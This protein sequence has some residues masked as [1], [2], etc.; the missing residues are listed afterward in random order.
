MSSELFANS[1]L[2]LAQY[3]SNQG[4]ILQGKTDV[5]QT[6]SNP[7]NT[8]SYSNS[9]PMVFKINKNGDTWLEDARIVVLVSAATG[10]GGTYIRFVNAAGIFIFERFQLFQKGVEVDNSTADQVFTNLLF[11]KSQEELL[12]I[13]PRIAYD[14]TVNSVTN[15]NTLA[16]SQQ[17]FVLDVRRMFGFFNKPLDISLIDGDLEVRAWF[18]NNLTY[19]LQTDKT[20]PT[21]SILDCY[22]DI[23]YVVPSQKIVEATRNQY[24]K[25]G[26]I[27][28]PKYDYEL[29]VNDSNILLAGS[30]ATSL[31]LPEL[32]NKLVV[33]IVIIARATGLTNTSSVSDYT[34][35]QIQM[36]QYSLL[37]GSKYLH[38]IEK[39]ITDLYF[40]RI[41]L[42]RL[43]YRGEINMV[44]RNEYVISFAADYANQ[45]SDSKYFIG[46]RK[47]MEN[48][49]RIDLVY[50]TLAANTQA[51]ILIRC[52]RLKRV[53]K[54]TIKNL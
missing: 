20:A 45:A 9:T 52:A 32:Y 42:P 36:T 8:P 51:I 7:T 19:V 3:V 53:E 40:K 22:S 18:R 27:S 38:G 1:D 29:V 34:D 48:D 41:I 23:K 17:T 10:T 26:Y 43:K 28:E 50:P 12:N 35:T 33:D 24:I 4:Q 21:F 49:A 13:S 15:R 30:T 25:N 11:F 46:A 37:S 2:Q 31:R 6:P 14:A 16:A 54:G 5:V 44:P 39:P 47:F